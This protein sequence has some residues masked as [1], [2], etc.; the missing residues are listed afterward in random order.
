MPYFPSKQSPFKC[1]FSKTSLPFNVLDTIHNHPKDFKESNGESCHSSSGGESCKGCSEQKDDG[2]LIFTAYRELFEEAGIKAELFDAFTGSPL[3]ET[4]QKTCKQNGNIYDKIN[5]Y[6][7]GIM[8]S[9]FNDTKLDPQTSWEL[10]DY[11]W[12]TIADA[13]KMLS[14]KRYNMVLNALP[15]VGFDA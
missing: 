2:N 8:K 11:G 4:K 15:Q 13:K 3:I 9:K 10:S 7:T 1:V 6:F 12:Y 14:N 5:Y